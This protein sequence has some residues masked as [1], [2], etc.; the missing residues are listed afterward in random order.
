M[1]PARAGLGLI[2]A[3]V[4][5]AVVTATLGG[6][7][8]ALGARERE[9]HAETTEAQLLALLLDGERCTLD[10]LARHG[11]AFFVPPG[12][13]ALRILATETRAT[14]APTGRP[15]RLVVTLYDGLGGLPAHL[16]GQDGPLAGCR[17]PGAATIPFP[18]LPA[19][20]PG[21]VS[22]AL[23]RVPLSEGDRFP[24]PERLT[25]DAPPGEP[26]LAEWVMPHSDGRVH[27]NGLPLALA[28]RLLSNPDAANTELLTRRAAGAR[29]TLAAPR[30]LGETGVVLVDRTMVWHAWIHLAVGDQTRNWWLVITRADG[31]APRRVQRHA[32]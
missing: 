6:L 9:R 12:D 4:A 3:L 17:P 24:N 15:C 14:A 13:A 20:A 32:F 19:G 27:L 28:E 18:P 29:I 22:D 26:A 31:S 30:P 16:L 5:V 1:N 23:L 2:L 7:L 10:W 11:D 21:R 25:A 8:L